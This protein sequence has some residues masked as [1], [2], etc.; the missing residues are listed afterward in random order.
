M[1]FILS[2]TFL[3]EAMSN[4]GVVSQVKK[5]LRM[6]YYIYKRDHWYTL[7]SLPHSLSEEAE[8]NVYP[9]QL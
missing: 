6:A 9:L 5:I 8:S 2:R 1:Y 4:Q 3:K 7:K